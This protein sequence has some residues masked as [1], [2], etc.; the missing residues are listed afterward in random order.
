MGGYESGIWKKKEKEKKKEEEK[1]EEEEEEGEEEGGEEERERLLSSPCENR[2]ISASL[3]AERSINCS[4]SHYLN[5]AIYRSSWPW[6]SFYLLVRV[7]SC[8]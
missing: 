1:E 6:I 3:R 7:P 4:H 2:Q 8:T 5:V